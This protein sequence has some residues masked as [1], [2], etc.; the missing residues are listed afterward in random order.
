MLLA[1]DDD[2]GDAGHLGDLLGHKVVGVVV[3]FN[4]TKS[5]WSF[6]FLSHM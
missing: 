2:L 5:G 4:S 3:C 1:E 6:D